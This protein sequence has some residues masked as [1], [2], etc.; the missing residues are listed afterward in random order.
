MI[1]RIPRY[2]LS[3]LV[4][5]L[6]QVLL[7]NNIQ[8]SGYLNPY[9]YILFILSLPNDIPDWALLVLAF[10]LGITVDLF[11]HTVGMHSSAT[12][13]MAF[14]RPTILRSL[15]P[16][17]GYEPDTRPSVQEYGFNWYFK[18]AALM[19]LVHHL[20]LFYIEVFKVSDFFLTFSRAILSAIFSLIIILLTKLFIKR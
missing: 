18:Y 7:L 13:F 4:L 2:V 1:N 19:V 16:R 17:G 8:L 3:F 15:E 10:F 14:L 6:I 20:F 5:V 11:S 9:I 12:V